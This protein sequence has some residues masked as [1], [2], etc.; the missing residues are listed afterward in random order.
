MARPSRSQLKFILILCSLIIWAP[1]AYKLADPLSMQFQFRINGVEYIEDAGHIS[2]DSEGTY[3]HVRPDKR[4]RAIYPNLEPD[5]YRPGCLDCTRVST[6]M[7]STMKEF[8]VIGS[9]KDLPNIYFE[10]PCQTSIPLH[11]GHTTVAAVL[12]F[13]PIVLIPLLRSMVQRMR[14]EGPEPLIPPPSQ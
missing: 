8:C 9:R 7:L 14:G 6:A 12:F 1:L 2:R 5:V 13:L 11:D 10:Q 4:V 3:F